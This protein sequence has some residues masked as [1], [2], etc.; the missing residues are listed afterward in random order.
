VDDAKNWRTNFI[1]SVEKLEY[2]AFELNNYRDWEKDEFIIWQK[3]RLVITPNF[4]TEGEE[5]K[6]ATCEISF[7]KELAAACWQKTDYTHLDFKMLNSFTS[8][9]AIRFYEALVAKIQYYT[10]SNNYKTEYDFKQ[11]ELEGIF[12]MKLSSVPIGFKNFLDNKIHFDDVV[13]PDLQSKLHFDYEIH[14]KDKII[15]FKFQ[16]DYL[17]QFRTRKADTVDL[18]I[19]KFRN[20]IDAKKHTTT[21]IREFMR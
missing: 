5:C 8:K 2:I 14:S 17:E 16:K 6:K 9:Y 13:I 21:D 19:E 4:K 15:T 10:N 11:D 18:A 7:A 3:T 12:Y 20:L 1:K